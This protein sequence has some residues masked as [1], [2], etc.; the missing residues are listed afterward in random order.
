MS[1]LSVLLNHFYLTLDAVTYRAVAESE[2]LRNKFA[3]NEIRTTHRTDRSY[4]GLYFY[5]EK[6][7]FEFFDAQTETNRAPGD[8]A[9]AFGLEHEGE[10]ALLQQHW[11][12]AKRLTITRPTDQHQVDWFEMLIPTGFT[13][14]SPIAVWSMEYVPSFLKE[15]RSPSSTA[16]EP[17]IARAAI[18]ARY[19]TLIATVEK[20]VLRDVIGLTLHA[21]AFVFE[22]FAQFAVD[23]G[24][25][26]TITENGFRFSDAE[27]TTYHIL[28]APNQGHG[29]TKVV[30]AVNHLPSQPIWHF[31]HSTLTF[32]ADLTAVWEF[33]KL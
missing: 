22:A 3:P 14:E 33:R 1:P 18:L 2:F 15:W 21:D 5:G 8:S 23:F 4:T 25:S 6:T 20:P 26:K 16:D 29:I 17:R 11:L 9:I 24:Y 32:T 13:L 30:F 12:G 7:Y 31:G 19:K 10:T 27:G 28:P